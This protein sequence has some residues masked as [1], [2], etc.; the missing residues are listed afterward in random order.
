[1]SSH[2][3]LIVALITSGFAS[4]PSFAQSSDASGSRSPATDSY[5]PDTGASGRTGAEATGKGKRS[6]DPTQSRG[7][8]PSRSDT[9]VEPESPGSRAEQGPGDSIGKS[10][11]ERPTHQDRKIP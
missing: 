2:R 1:M 11:P 5:S 6:R 3:L 9:V 8:R 7:A 4:A 10:V